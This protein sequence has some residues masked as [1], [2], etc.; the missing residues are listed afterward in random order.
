MITIAQAAAKQALTTLTHSTIAKTW[1]QLKKNIPVRLTAAN[2][3]DVVLETWAYTDESRNNGIMQIAV[4]VP[5]ADDDSAATSVTLDAS[6]LKKLVSA[7]PTSRALSIDTVADSANTVRYTVPGTSIH[8]KIKTTE[9]VNWPRYYQGASAV[10]CRIPVQHLATLIDRAAYA[11]STEPG[12]QIVLQGMCLE[13]DVA[14]NTVTGVGCDGFRIGRATVEADE[15]AG[16]NVTCIVPAS[17][18][19]LVRKLITAKTTGSAKIAAYDGA[20]SISVGA[21][22]IL[23]DIIEAEYVN[24]KPYFMASASN[25]ARNLDRVALLEAVKRAEALLTAQDAWRL[26]LTVGAGGIDPV[27]TVESQGNDMTLTEQVSATTEGDEL[28]I[29]VNP[30]FLR[31]ALTSTCA[32]TVDLEMTGPNKPCIIMESGRDAHALIL[33]ILS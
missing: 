21:V 32:P 2:S 18:V 23:A 7:L 1:K 14:G 28:H 12:R 15:I 26:H 4:T 8:G 20:V 27:L 25:C 30:T 11:M 29:I 5:R 24:Y 33:P 22:E 9:I 19:R 3:V 17:V 16:G 6:A 31:D 10:T 13:F